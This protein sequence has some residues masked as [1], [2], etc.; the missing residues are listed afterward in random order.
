MEVVHRLDDLLHVHPDFGSGWAL[1]LEDGE[2]VAVA[3]RHDDAVRVVGQGVPLDVLD[4][5]R[6]LGRGQEVGRQDDVA[7]IQ[8][9]LR[10]LL[11]LELVLL[12]HELDHN[13][14]EWS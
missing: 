14:G 11:A 2:K 13:L 5:G 6:K 12:L 3:G 4:R 7:S 8:G 1:G 9:R 10:L